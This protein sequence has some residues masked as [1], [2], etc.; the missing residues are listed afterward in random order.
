MDKKYYDDRVGKEDFCKRL[1]EI[2]KMIKT[3]D[4]NEPGWEFQ[5]VNS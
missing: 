1:E 4:Q 2:Y 5:Y 3:M